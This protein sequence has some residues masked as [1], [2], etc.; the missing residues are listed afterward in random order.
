MLI[1]FF[2]CCESISLTPSYY[3]SLSFALLCGGNE[4][5]E[6]KKKT[7]E[8][9][10]VLVTCIC[11]QD[12]QICGAVRALGFGGSKLTVMLTAVHITSVHL[13]VN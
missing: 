9:A 4:A 7:F 12:F 6:E 3:L 5:S 10:V 8:A 1:T 2:Q 13:M 11:R